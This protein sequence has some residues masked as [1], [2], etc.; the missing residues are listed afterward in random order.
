MQGIGRAREW[1]GEAEV[2]EGGGIGHAAIRG[3]TA[4]IWL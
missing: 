2:A 1:N 3:V 4:C